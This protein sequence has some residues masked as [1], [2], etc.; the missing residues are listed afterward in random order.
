MMIKHTPTPIATP[1]SVIV[2]SDAIGAKNGTRILSD[3][4]TEPKITPN[5]ADEIP[6]R[7][8]TSPSFMPYNL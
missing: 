2:F 1:N 7:I 4:N 8:P 6:I 5:I 3:P